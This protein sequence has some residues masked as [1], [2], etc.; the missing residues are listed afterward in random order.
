MLISQFPKKLLSN[1][2]YTRCLTTVSFGLRC[3]I[4]YNTSIKSKE[5]CLKNKFAL[6]QT[7][8]SFV[9]IQYKLFS[10]DLIDKELG[11]LLYVGKL[12]AKF[13]CEFLMTFLL[14]FKLYCV[15]IALF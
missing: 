9:K 1:L 7:N 4:P 15:F 14:N 10:K 6:L 8:S 13:K 2:P 5:R 3:N 11:K 12:E